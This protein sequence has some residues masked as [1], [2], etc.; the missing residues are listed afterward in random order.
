MQS[1]CN[2]MMMVCSCKELSDFFIYTPSKAFAS[3]Y[4]WVQ[5]SCW[6][7]CQVL[8]QKKYMLFMSKLIFSKRKKGN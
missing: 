8:M 3:N 7:E 4:R 5:D 1:V 2:F 6:V